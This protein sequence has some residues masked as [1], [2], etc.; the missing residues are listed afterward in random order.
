MQDVVELL[1]DRDGLLTFEMLE[2]ASIM[3]LDPCFAMMNSRRG[4]RDNTLSTKKITQG[5]TLPPV[6]DEQLESFMTR[7]EIWLPESWIACNDDEVEEFSARDKVLSMKFPYALFEPFLNDISA[8]RPALFAILKDSNVLEADQKWTRRAKSRRQRK[9]EDRFLREQ[10][11]SNAFEASSSYDQHSLSS[12]KMSC[13]MGCVI[14]KAIADNTID[15]YLIASYLLLNYYRKDKSFVLPVSNLLASLFEGSPS[16]SGDFIQNSTAFNP[17][18][19]SI[20]SVKED[21]AKSISCR[22]EVSECVGTADESIAGLQSDAGSTIESNNADIGTETA[23]VVEAEMEELTEDEMLAHALAMSMSESSVPRNRF[24]SAVS[25]STTSKSAFFS[26]YPCLE[27]SFWQQL[28]VGDCGDGNQS[29]M[30]PTLHAA[31]ALLMCVSASLDLY[32]KD[33]AMVE[34]NSKFPSISSTLLVGSQTN[35]L[36][37]CEAFLHD[38][39]AVYRGDD[40]FN[41]SDPLLT[42]IPWSMWLV[43]RMTKISATS[44]MHD[45]NCCDEGAKLYQSKNSNEESSLVLGNLRSHVSSALG[46]NP[47]EMSEITS[48]VNLDRSPNLVPVRLMMTEALA[49]LYCLEYSDDVVKLF[50]ALRNTIRKAPT[51]K[52]LNEGQ[53]P[54]IFFEIFFVHKLCVHVVDNV[55]LSFKQS[56][57][58]RNRALT[59]ILYPRS[60]DDLIGVDTSESI[61][62]LLLQRLG[63]ADLVRN[64]SCCTDYVQDEIIYFGELALLRVLQQMRLKV[65]NNYSYDECEDLDD[66]RINPKRCSPTLRIFNEQKECLHLGPKSW[67]TAVA[68]FPITPKTGTYEFSVRIEKCDKGHVFVGLVSGEANVDTYIGGDKH[69]FGMIGT[70]AGVIF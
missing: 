42:F 18:R 56:G 16:N 30:I 22:N 63:G 7:Q 5:G 35:I 40:V 19:G 48:N 27:T 70:R 15:S 60:F 45:G 65:Y 32:Y 6:I 69:G 67:A 37:L 59:T 12:E 64:S 43:C 33:G 4:I 51:F 9:Q 2:R 49:C 47:I 24:A 55:L 28:S 52:E 11:I 68:S 31:T 57:L 66:L 29:S 20:M 8:A 14:A 3:G 34:H 17:F 23:S 61:E 26:F 38:L 53:N 13:L 25:Q 62:E 44:L 41:S 58:L 46:F 1:A 21:D 39:L 10:H 36:H 54:T 50:A